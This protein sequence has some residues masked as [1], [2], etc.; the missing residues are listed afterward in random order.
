MSIE[1]CPITRLCQIDIC[2]TNLHVA[3]V[4]MYLPVHEADSLPAKWECYPLRGVLIV[5]SATNCLYSTRVM[6]D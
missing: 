3:D 1:D 5:P 6:S 4:T 2:T